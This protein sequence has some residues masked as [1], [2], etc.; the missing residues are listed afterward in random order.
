MNPILEREIATIRNKDT[1]ARYFRESLENVGYMLGMQIAENLDTRV[2]EITTP[3]GT[4]YHKIPNQEVVLVPILRA[5][6]PVY[7]GLQRA[8]PDAESGFVGMSRASDDMYL[9][10]P[11]LEGKTVILADTMIATGDSI[12]RAMRVINNRGRAEA[13]KDRTW[14]VPGKY[15]IAGVLGSKEAVDGLSDLDEYHGSKLETYVAAVDP[16]LN[17]DYF[18]IPGLGDAGDRCYGVAR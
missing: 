9:S 2:E 4:A 16:I 11:D 8:F 17:E 18:I 12:C 13:L 10:M 1:P 7:N 15:I 3:M 14:G 6:L 5:G